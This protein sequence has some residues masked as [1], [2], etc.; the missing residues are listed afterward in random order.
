MNNYGARK[1]R[2]IVRYLLRNLQRGTVRGRENYG[3]LRAR[4]RKAA[5]AAAANRARRRR[6]WNV[7]TPSPPMAYWCGAGGEITFQES[8][9][10]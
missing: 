5:A 2:P 8:G 7:I 9:G 1:I 4:T 3:S 6:S 10:R